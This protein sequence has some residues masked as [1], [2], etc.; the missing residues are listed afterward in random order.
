MG[1]KN[2]GEIINTL[3]KGKGI[4]QEE[5]ANHVGVSTQAVSKWECGGVPDT[6]L[7]PIIADY[8]EVSIDTLFGRS[9]NDYGDIYSAVMRKIS[10][11]NENERF[12]EVF[13]LL[14]VIQQA[15]IGKIDKKN[16]K[17]L[18]EIDHNNHT[19]SQIRWDSGVSMFDLTKQSPYAFF[20]PESDERSDWLL[21]DVD[22]LSLFKILAEQDTFNTLVFL[23]KRNKGISFTPKLLEK[24]LGITAER[25]QEIID[26][27]KKYHFIDTTEIELD[28]TTQYVYAL[29][30]TPS[31]IAILTFAREIIKLPNIFY[32]YHGGR[33]K[34][35]LK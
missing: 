20:M 31:F 3:R 32:I 24:S 28:D 23:Y 35:Y 14:W 8:F 16:I 7:I 19:Y 9:I 30:N 12:N 17:K 29:N 11:L 25:A 6:E 22:Y 33:E 18:S 21:N 4:T 15:I 1:I 13:E 34:P 27:L 10:S 26:S 2:I 5:L